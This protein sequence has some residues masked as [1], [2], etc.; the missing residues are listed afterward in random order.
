MTLPEG[1]R[2]VPM[3]ERHIEALAQ[4]EMLCFSDP[5]SRN[6]LREELRNPLA[7][8]FVAEID[9][10]AVGYAGLNFVLDEGYIANIAVHP[11][12]RR[13]G[14][15]AALL[16]RL[17]DFAHKKNLSYLTLEVRQSNSRAIGIYEKA[18]FRREGRRKN[19]YENPREDALIMTKRFEAGNET[20]MEP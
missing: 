7:A 8:F 11:D 9:G 14:A 5:W 19:F 15:A 10:C 16:Q 18:G 20:E 1:L 4:L 17:A 6:A 13:R 3:E 12:F 2:I